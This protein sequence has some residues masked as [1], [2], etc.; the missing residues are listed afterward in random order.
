MLFMVDIVTSQLLHM[1][2]LKKNIQYTIMDKY[3]VSESMYVD[4]MYDNVC[5]NTYIYLHL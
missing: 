4:V 1:W 5:V 2:K 3:S